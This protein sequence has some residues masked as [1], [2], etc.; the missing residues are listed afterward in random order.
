VQPATAGTKGET[1]LGIGMDRLQFLILKDSQTVSMR[2]GKGN[3]QVPE[4]KKR[5]FNPKRAHAERRGAR[6]R[7]LL[8]RP[9]SG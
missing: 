8:K 3:F 1:H 6:G 9:G 5:F 4:G 7:G 2:G